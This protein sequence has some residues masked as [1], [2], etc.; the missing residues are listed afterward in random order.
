M[1]AESRQIEGPELRLALRAL[2]PD[3]DP[4]PILFIHGFLD[5]GGTF[6][7]IAPALAHTRRCLLIDRRGY[8]DSERHP[9]RRYGFHDNLLDLRAIIADTKAERVDLVGHSAG[10]VIATAYAGAFP[11]QVR[12]LVIVD[13]WEFREDLDQAPRRTRDWVLAHSKQAPQPRSYKDLDQAIARLAQFHPKVD[14]AILERWAARGT[15][16]LPDGTLA[17]KADPRHK[18]REPAFFQRAII[19]AYIKLITA[20]TLAIRGQD[21]VVTAFP[22]WLEAFGERL[23]RLTIPEAG[24]MLHLE[25]PEAFR[26][27]LDSFLNRD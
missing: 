14:P 19:E 16:P 10:G 11:E 24:H 13:P 9:H 18:V 7:P 8:G 17:F 2:G 1:D 23:A 22:T 15:S 5:H 6:D 4:H 26:K 25:R 20:E 12:R 3:S 27:A 21:S